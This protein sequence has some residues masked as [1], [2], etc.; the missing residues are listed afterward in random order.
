MCNLRLQAVNPKTCLIARFVYIV[1]SRSS[2]S[3]RTCILMTSRDAAVCTYKM[4]KL[5]LPQ[6]ILSRNSSVDS[7]L[8][9]GP[10]EPG[11]IPGKA[12]FFGMFFFFNDGKVIDTPPLRHVNTD[13]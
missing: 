1:T 3:T 7:T 13:C 2:H 9:F 12:F 5:F 8:A 6:I 10:G 11:S 4:Y